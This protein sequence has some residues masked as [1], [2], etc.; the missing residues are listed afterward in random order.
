MSA[1]GWMP[2]HVAEYVADTTHLS[3]AEHGAYLLLIMHYWQNR[4]LPADD[5]K[6]ARICRM[7]RDEFADSRETLMA[8]FSHKGRR[9]LTSHDRVRG[10]GKSTNRPHIAPSV[11]ARVLKRD[12]YACIYC[13]AH[14]AKL[15]LDHLIPWSRGGLTT[16]DN[17]AVACVS[18]NT[19]KG[20]LTADEFREWRQ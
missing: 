5:A 12:R 13:G 2:L 3:T 4:G 18:C 6:L 11:R 14:D 17:L 8:L 19:S 15:H 7:S 20:A 10:I 9:G 16:E 1:P